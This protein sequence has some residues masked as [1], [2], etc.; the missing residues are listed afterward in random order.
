MRRRRKLA[1]AG[2]LVLGGLL[3]AA[4]L[5]RGDLP[6]ADV[7]SRSARSAGAST[8]EAT[9]PVI[10]EDEEPAS[11]FGLAPPRAVGGAPSHVARLD[12]RIDE[13]DDRV[14]AAEDDFS[15]SSGSAARRAH[16]RGDASA[17]QSG[18][19]PLDDD[20]WR[21]SSR[22]G[23]WQRFDV[24]HGRIGASRDRP[25]D[26]FEAL[27]SRPAEHGP[28]E[29]GPAEYGPAEYDVVESVVDDPA[30]EL[31]AGDHD[32]ID[33]RSADRPTGEVV[34]RIRDGDTLMGLARRYLGSRDRYWEI[35]D[36]NRDRLDDPDL[37]P[38]GVEIRIPTAR[39]AAGKERDGPPMVPV[40][41]RSPRR[42]R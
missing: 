27:P 25:A 18:Q 10:V 21:P 23:T 16:A 2:G 1:I 3:I 35:Y 33:G 36:A 24:G 8:S 40:G 15:T 31:A 28:A 41:R 12:E 14:G 38:I 9:L 6:R 42:D 7:A 4:S 39:T 19:P 37:L 17:E 34:H 32:G 22:I 13:G 30:G 11:L 5:R 26:S 20:A 29:Y